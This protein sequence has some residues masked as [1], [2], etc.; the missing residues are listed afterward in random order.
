MNMGEYN[1][2]LNRMFN[3]EKEKNIK[4]EVESKIEE[5]SEIPQEEIKSNIIVEEKYEMKTK[6][7]LL[8]DSMFLFPCNLVFYLF[9]YGAMFLLLNGIGL[10]DH[11]II[12]G[13]RMVVAF[14]LMVIMLVFSWCLEF[15]ALVIFF[16]GLKNVIKKKDT[17][18][19]TVLL[20][21]SILSLISNPIM[22][23]LTS[24]L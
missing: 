9:L 1:K 3:P 18:Y 6:K 14:G 10:H 7:T 15:Y 23:H 11:G 24:F 21:L 12:V 4:K 8:K 20:F 13:T 2:M 19:N 16:I 22:S 17:K 5:T